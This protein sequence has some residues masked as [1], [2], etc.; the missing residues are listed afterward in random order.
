[1]PSGESY[2]MNIPLQIRRR[3][4]RRFDV[5][6]PN[7]FIRTYF[8]MEVETSQ[9]L[10]ALGPDIGLKVANSD[11]RVNSVFR[12]NSI[13]IVTTYLIYAAIALWG[14]WT[15]T[16]LN[17]VLSFTIAGGALLAAVF[18]LLRW[19][20]NRLTT[21]DLATVIL[22]FT[23]TILENN[24]A[25]WP[26]SSFR[27]QIARRIERI[28]RRVE[29]IPLAAK[30]LA[31]DIKEETLRLGR[32]KAQAIRQL[33][34]WVIR[35]MAFTFTDLICQLTSDLNLMVEGRW[36]DL[37]EANGFKIERPKWVLA[38]IIGAAVIVAGGA[39]FLVAFAAKTSPAASIIGL[40]LAGAALA[41]LNN[42]GIS[43]GLIDQYLQT[44][45]KIISS[46]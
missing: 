29:L 42:V 14:V 3:L 8:Q 38:L 34:L 26:D 37:P 5:Y 33:E 19:R 12:S 43:T 24:A 15:Q 27:W 17:W 30:S 46:K 10:Q 45:S 44:G 7:S 36:H 13:I 40:I 28:A 9:S 39:I 31:P 25:S 35:P 16:D 41:L 20:A 32:A 11:A 4:Y 2:Q 6:L 18:L 23:I 22:F 1:M 21:E